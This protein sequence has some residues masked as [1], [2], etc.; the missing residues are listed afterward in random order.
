MVQIAGQGVWLVD[1]GL[2]PKRLTLTNIKKEKKLERLQCVCGYMCWGW[3]CFDVA[4]V[5]VLLERLQLCWNRL[6]MMMVVVV[7][8]VCGYWWWCCDVLRFCDVQEN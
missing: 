1:L 7:E 8:T 4:M 5:M 6:L 3:F 2:K